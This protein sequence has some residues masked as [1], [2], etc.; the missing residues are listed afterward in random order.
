[1]VEV[2]KV[3]LPRVKEDHKENYSAV[4]QELKEKTKELEEK[5]DIL[6]HLLLDEIEKDEKP[7]EVSERAEYSPERCFWEGV[8]PL[9]VLGITFALMGLQS[10]G[11]KGAGPEPEYPVNFTEF[12]R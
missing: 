10:V 9:I 4:I 11:E 3:V 8:V 6:S 5:L 12:R 1:M 7:K 2:E